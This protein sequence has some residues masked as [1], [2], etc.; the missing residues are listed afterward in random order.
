MLLGN[1]TII[2]CNALGECIGL[3][4][5]GQ[6]H[7]KLDLR[8]S[9][10]TQTSYVHDERARCASNVDLL[11]C[12]RLRSSKL[13]EDATMTVGQSLSKAAS[14]QLALGTTPYPHSN[15]NPIKYRDFAN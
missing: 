3:M 9:H 12:P 5:K 11:M 6:L 14:I 10:S 4:A 2:D 15:G 7:L 8:V 13:S 1:N